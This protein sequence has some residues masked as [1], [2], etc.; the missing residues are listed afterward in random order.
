MFNYL[1]VLLLHLVPNSHQELHFHIHLQSPMSH[2]LIQELRDIS[3]SIR[4][5]KITFHRENIPFHQQLSQFFR[6]LVPH[7][8][9][10]RRKS[11]VSIDRNSLSL[12]EKILHRLTSTCHL[13]KQLFLLD[14]L[15][16][17]MKM[18]G[19]SFT[20]SPSSLFLLPRKA[21]KVAVSR[22]WLFQVQAIIIGSRFAR[23]SLLAALEIEI[24]V[25]FKVKHDKL[26]LYC[27]IQNMDMERTKRAHTPLRVHGT[28]VP[29]NPRLNSLRKEDSQIIL[30][31][32]R[33]L[34]FNDIL[35]Y[36][37]FKKRKL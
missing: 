10:S 2:P 12:Q 28:H 6:A 9:I 5:E 32:G 35:K 36:L 30:Q 29:E 22:N 31:K 20:F 37:N 21:G 23:K 27:I 17:E 24:L 14:F 18:T 8:Y 1:R 4:D 11:V 34:Y 26:I 25:T 16:C 7:I 3:G 19:F 15:S 13:E 33:I